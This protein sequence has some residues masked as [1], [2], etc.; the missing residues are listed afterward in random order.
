M[1]KEEQKKIRTPE[2]RASFAHVFKAQR[3]P[4]GDERFSVVMLFP[5]NAD[6]SGL[7]QLAYE[8]A[9]KKFGK[10]AIDGKKI[11]GLRSPFRDGEEKS[12]KYDGYEGMIFV[13]ASTK[14]KPKVVDKDPSVLL[15]GDSE[16]YSGCYGR[17][18]VNAYA[19]DNKGNKGVAFGL[20]SIQKTRDG[21][22]F[23]MSSNPEEDY[24]NLS[25][26]GQSSQDYG[27]NDEALFG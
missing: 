3:T 10:D 4:S 26:D 17:A 18:M 14:N 16:F 12:D 22:A 21:E 23:G 20:I 2:F 25:D 6:L 5:K 1:A 27:S 15:H 11:K 19:Y 24:D 9:C 7:K 8:A 13:T